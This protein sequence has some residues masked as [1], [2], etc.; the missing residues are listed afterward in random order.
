LAKDAAGSIGILDAGNTGSTV[1]GIL[2]ISG[3]GVKRPLSV[4]LNGT[5]LSA[6][7]DMPRGTLFIAPHPLDNPITI[8]GLDLAFIADAGSDSQ[9]VAFR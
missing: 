6:L 8:P 5:D 9:T 3:A 7:P 4:S 1:P 2:T